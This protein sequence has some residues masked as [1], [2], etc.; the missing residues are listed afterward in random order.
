MVAPRQAGLL[1]RQSP[2][3]LG[4]LEVRGGPG[5]ILGRGPGGQ[6]GGGEA[7]LER[8]QGGE[9]CG[10][11]GCQ[12]RTGQGRDGTLIYSGQVPRDTMFPLFSFLFMVGK[13]NNGIFKVE[14]F[15]WEA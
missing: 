7:G 12:W 8:P 3:L 4:G 10:S 14:G 9:E 5:D 11:H 6:G 2:L 15:V 1:A 13:K